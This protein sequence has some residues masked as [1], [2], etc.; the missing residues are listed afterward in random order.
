MRRIAVFLAIV[1]VG[2]CDSAAPPTVAETCTEATLAGKMEKFATSSAKLTERAMST[3][4]SSAAAEF[5]AFAVKIAQQSLE[6]SKRT[7]VHG[8]DRAYTLQ[9]CSDYDA[10]QAFVDEAAAQSRGGRPEKPAARS[11]AGSGGAG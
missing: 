6:M 2:A 11:T 1:A 9:L 10:L 5:Q 7:Q 3:A 8:D 4:G